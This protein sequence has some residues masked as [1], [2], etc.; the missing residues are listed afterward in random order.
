VAGP[1]WAQHISKAR[2]TL[3]QAAK[4][5]LLNSQKQQKSTTICLNDVTADVHGTRRSAAGAF[6]KPESDL[7]L[8][9]TPDFHLPPFETTQLLKK[10][11]QQPGGG[12]I[13]FPP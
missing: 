12:N 1:D 7:V 11:T 8:S 10:N 13:F 3:K 5:T 2:T 6:Q 9:W 4:K